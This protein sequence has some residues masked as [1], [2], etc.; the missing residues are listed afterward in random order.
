LLRSNPALAFAVANG[1][2]LVSGGRRGEYFDTQF[3]MAYRQQRDVLRRLGFPATPRARRV[4]RK[5]IPGA[6]TVRH[7]RVLRHA[8]ANERLAKRL[9]HLPCVN[10]AVLAMLENG[11]IDD[12]PQAALVRVARQDG[13]GAADPGRRLSDALRV[14]RLT[15]AAAT[16]APGVH[17]RDDAYAASMA[18]VGSRVTRWSAD[19][20]PPPPIPGTALIVPIT[21]KDMLREEG[22][23]QKNCVAGYLSSVM[24]RQAYVYRVLAPQR[25]TLSIVPSGEE[26]VCGQL[27]ARAN[28]PASRIAFQ[29]V[30]QWLDTMQPDFSFDPTGDGPT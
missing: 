21:S 9:V 3:L 24:R 29:M 26:W 25:C 27:K 5:I 17:E 1:A 7:L 18:P 28:G 11:A 16:A 13:A 22:R 4:L 2:D 19:G 6:V 8:L 14:W 20:F 12:V 10:G 30:D 15:P 23:V